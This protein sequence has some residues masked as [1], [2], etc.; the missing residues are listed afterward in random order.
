VCNGGKNSV[1]AR[2]TTSCDHAVGAVYSNGFGSRRSGFVKFDLILQT[3]QSIPAATFALI[4]F[5][6]LSAA[7]LVNHILK[8]GVYTTI[9]SIPSLL[10]A[11]VFAHATFVAH[12]IYFSPDKASNTAI[13]VSSGFI[14]LAGC[15]LLIFRVFAAV[16]DRN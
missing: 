2:L 8:V 3:A 4:L 6:S 14:V 9:A 13:A 11:G 1:N 16:N 15:A 7:L 5:M 10:F 12:N